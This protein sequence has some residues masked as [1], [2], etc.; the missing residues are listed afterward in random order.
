MFDDATDAQLRRYSFDA[1]AFDQLRQRLARGEFEKDANRLDEPIALPQAGD[2]MPWPDDGEHPHLAAAIERIDAGQVAVA[3]LNGGMATR[4]GGRVKG[5]VQAFGDASFLQLKLR[6]AHQAAPRAHIFL[7]NSFATAAATVA[8][9]EQHQYFGVPKNQVH[10]IEQRICVRLRPDGELYIGDNGQPSFY[11]PGHGDLLAALAAAPMFARLKQQGHLH[12][13]VSNVDNLGATV[14]PK[15]IA[16]HLA[17][18]KSI[19]CEVAQRR[20]GDAGGAPV[21]RSGHLEVLEEFRFPKTFD[22]QRCPVFN[23]NTFV[24]D[25]AVIHERHPLSWFRADKVVDGQP[26][27]QF[28]R[29]LGEVTS[30]VDATFLLV[31]RD[32]GLSRFLPVKAPQDL[33]T[34]QAA[35]AERFAPGSR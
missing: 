21:R 29:L 20:A 26:V 23:T 14:D 4:F 31:P 22:V 2:L 34:I 1:A 33:Q 32:G 7:M 16:A 35:V 10:L 24:L 11:A 5:V 25:G 13:M 19:T 27:V 6:Q 8:H 15:V 17:G 12:V 30:F 9:L 18:G 28:E 3:I